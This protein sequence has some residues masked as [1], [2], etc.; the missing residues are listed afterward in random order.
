MN[1]DEAIQHCE[2]V[3][4]QCE[5][6]E[7]TIPKMKECASEHHQLAEWLKE[8]KAYKEQDSDTIS[9]QAVI[10]TIYDNKSDFK[11]DFAQGFFADRIRDLPSATPQPKTGRTIQV[12]VQ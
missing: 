12:D 3:A 10:S 1:L 2:E 5:G 9:R 8:L 6:G 7:Y 4:T 11:N